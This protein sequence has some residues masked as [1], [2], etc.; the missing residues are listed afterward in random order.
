MALRYA[1]ALPLMITTANAALAQDSTDCRSG[2]FFDDP[3]F[4]LAEVNDRGR[5]YFHGDMKGCP[6]TGGACNSPSY[7]VPGDTVIINR[8]RNGYA[9]GFY[10]GERGGNAGWLPTRQL[11]FLRMNTN[12]PLADW[13]GSWSSNG[14]PVLAISSRIGKLTVTGQSYWP[15]LPGTSDWPSTHIGELYGRLDRTGYTGTYGDS[16][17]CKIS[18]TLLA[19]YLIASDNRKCG[20]ANVSFSAVYERFED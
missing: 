15:G 4:A 3:P 12:P 20:G 13:V 2:L 16:N 7:V 19:P 10:P 14:N 11:T 5:A 9:C 1:L 17:L 8:I 6:W 18:F